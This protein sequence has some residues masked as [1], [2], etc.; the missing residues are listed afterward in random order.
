MN[1][2]IV[3]LILA[4][5]A[6]VVL[7]V[8]PLIWL[9]RTW[10]ETALTSQGGL[11]GTAVAV[12]F[13]WSITSPR[14]SQ[15]KQ[16]HGLAF[17]LLLA[18]ALT[19]LT[20]QI[21]GIN[22][23]GA[24]T[25]VIDV[26]AL[27]I[28]FGLNHRRRA[29]S[30]GWLAL[31][32]ALSLPIERIL[33]RVFGYPLQELAATIACQVLKLGQHSVTCS[34]IDLNIAGQNVLVDLPCAGTAALHTIMVVFALVACFKCP[35][36]RAAGVGL[37][38]ALIAALAGNVLRIVMLA[39]GIAY[40]QFIGGIDV[41]AAPWHEAI[42]VVTIAVPVAV[43]YVWS[44]RLTLPPMTPTNRFNATNL[45]QGTPLRGIV[46]PLRDA[47]YAKPV[48]GVGLVVLAIVIVSLP[49][50]PLDISRTMQPLQLPAWLNGHPATPL[51]L[52]R[53]EQQYFSQYGGAVARSAYGN[54]VLLVVKTSSP[55]RHIHSPDDCLRGMGHTVRYQ[56]QT[57]GRLPSAIY[58]S[59]D[60]DGRQWR[61]SVSYVSQHGQR[62]TSIGHAAWIWLQQP[63]STWTMVQRI[64]PWQE[65]N[66]IVQGFDD[67]VVTALD[68]T[69]SNPT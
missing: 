17:V 5:T 19:R 49:A 3:S 62:V 27:A 26:Y 39:L 14:P 32:F 6:A 54:Q 67:A 8:Q 13:V 60:P 41:M 45:V 25:L 48:L 55:L 2:R 11:I 34:G 7:A 59:T 53:L 44:R 31:L 1:T 16:T 56:G 47:R 36:W 21:L 57:R 18:S 69:F 30:P 37:T 29:V 46:S 15:G 42:G 33:Q 22:V 35:G 61:I 58:R 28:L 12:L 40:P 23:I 64:S 9:W 43:V 50:R 66:G 51:T 63:G 20:S 24:M 10:H 4:L 68:S 52:T 38:L 65:T